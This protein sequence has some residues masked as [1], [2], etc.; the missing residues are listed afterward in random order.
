M[1]EGSSKKKRTT[2]FY[3]HLKLLARLPV[4]FLLPGPRVFSPLRSHGA[5]SAG[6]F[7]NTSPLPDQG[8]TPACFKNFVKLIPIAAIR[9]GGYLLMKNFPPPTSCS[10]LSPSLPLTAQP[11]KQDLNFQQSAPPSRR[12][13][14]SRS[15]IM[16][17]SNPRLKGYFAPRASRSTSLST[18]RRSHQSR[19]H[20]LRPSDGNL[21]VL[22]WVENQRT[23]G[24][25]KDFIEF[26]Y[27][28][29]L[30]KRKVLIARKPIQGPRQ[31]ARL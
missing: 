4:I 26:T 18:R 9:I 22:E 21:Y 7:T 31:A 29:R 17:N 15:S 14:G 16:A 24:L 20:D 10:S 25:Q 30:E 12:P 11:A 5:N 2:C 1:Q 13:M 19:R 28:G 6:A 27:K 3:F 8:S 23:S